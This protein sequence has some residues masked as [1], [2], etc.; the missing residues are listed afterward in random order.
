[1]DEEF[2]EYELHKLGYCNG[3]CH[4]CNKEDAILEK[5]SKQARKISQETWDDVWER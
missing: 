1:M 3:H 4:Y 5:R 2:T